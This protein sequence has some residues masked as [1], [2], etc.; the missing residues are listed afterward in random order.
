MEC[1]I[2]GHDWTEDEF[3][4][5]IVVAKTS[6]STGVLS[7]PIRGIIRPS[8]QLDVAFQSQVYWNIHPYLVLDDHLFSNVTVTQWRLVS[9]SKLTPS[10][11]QHHCDWLM[12][13]A[14][15]YSLVCVALA[16]P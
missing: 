10:N 7:Y 2:I 6:S 16:T 9:A 15:I 4:W 3:L 13:L 14:R 12:E 5:H 11:V 8:F 1:F